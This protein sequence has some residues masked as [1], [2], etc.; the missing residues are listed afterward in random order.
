MLASWLFRS[1]MVLAVCLPLLAKDA[2]NEA[3]SVVVVLV[4][5]VAGWA[6]LPVQ[7]GFWANRHAS[8]IT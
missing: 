4:L 7:Y 1:P 6:A 8:N 2:R 5:W 3:P